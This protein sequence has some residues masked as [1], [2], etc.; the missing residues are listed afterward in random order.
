MAYDQ[1]RDEHEKNIEKLNSN[2]NRLDQD[3]KKKDIENEQLI[4]EREEMKDTL[5][6]TRTKIE[7]MEEEMKNNDLD[8]LQMAKEMETM[9]SKSKQIKRANTSLGRSVFRSAYRPES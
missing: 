4:K 1:I 5:K 9:T 3:N 2:K 6:R 8:N 7:E